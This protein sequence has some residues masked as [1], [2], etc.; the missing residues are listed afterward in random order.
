MKKA[1]LLGYLASASV[2]GAPLSAE[3]ADWHRGTPGLRFSKDPISASQSFLDSPK[4]R[5]ENVQLQHRRVVPLRSLSTV[6]YQQRHNGLPVVG[7]TVAVRI[8]HQGAV[9]VAVIDVARG[10]T[11]STVPMVSEAQAL[12]QVSGLLGQPSLLQP[13]H[14]SLVVLPLGDGVLAWHVDVLLPRGPHRF[15]VDARAGGVL[16]QYSLAQHAMGRVY[17]V[18]PIQTPSLQDVPITDLTDTDPPSLTGFDGSLKVYGYVSGDV[19]YGTVKGEQTG[20]SGEEG[21]LFDPNPVPTDLND[22]FS[23]VMSYYH[24]ARIRNYFQDTFGLDMSGSE[25]SLA[26]VANYAPSTSPEYIMNAFFAPWMSNY[27]AFPGFARNLICLGRGHSEDIAHDSDVLLHEFTHYVSHNAL[28][29]SNAGF[30][31]RYGYAAMQGAINEGTADYFS[32]T[33]NDD[34]AVGEYALGGW[35]RNLDDPVGMCPDNV[36]G[37]SHEDGKLIGSAGWALRDAFGA[38]TADQLVWGAMS[39][40]SN[41]ASLGDF[42]QGVLQTAKDLGLAASQMDTIEAILAQRGLDDCGR[43]LEIHGRSRTSYLMGLD[44]IGQYMGGSCS[45]VKNYGLFLTSIFQFSHTPKPNDTSAI[46]DVDLTL[47]G[48]GPLDWSLYVHR[49][50]LAPYNPGFASMKPSYFHDYAVKNITSPKAQIVIDESSDPPFDPETTYYV[51]IAH[52][53]CPMATLHVEGKGDGS[54]ELDAGTDAPTVDAG[55]GFDA[56]FDTG[57]GAGGEQGPS[58]EAGDFEPGGGCACTAGSGRSTAPLSAGLLMMMLLVLRRR[59]LGLGS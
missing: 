27:P 49:N 53:N 28:D 21:F 2:L 36:Y 24:T 29:Y 17:G 35:A 15:V 11:V 34:P 50:E 7:K 6:R 31:D 44:T 5:L 57:L 1:F 14:T 47:M 26:I 9:T 4:L 40:L 22:P 30:F 23:E 32:S 13:T 51:A 58:A 46:I 8:D 52:Q 59:K 41:T 25:Y 38:Q 33:L 20:P 48:G 37:E 39:L 16:E 54:Q 55:V 56:A 18:N 19:N 45:Q 12:A 43:S 3:A 10:L 42:G